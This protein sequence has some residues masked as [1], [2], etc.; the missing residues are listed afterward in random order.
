MNCKTK[1]PLCCRQTS[2]PSNKPNLSGFASR[3]KFL[4]TTLSVWGWF[5]ISL[6]EWI[7]CHRFLGGDK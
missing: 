2:K 1:I 4:I 5:P 3:I 6:A 7:I